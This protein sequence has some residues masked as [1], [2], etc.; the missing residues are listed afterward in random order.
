MTA[1]ELDQERRQTFDLARRALQRWLQAQHA[2]HVAVS[3]ER[4]C[5]AQ[6][7]AM[8]DAVRI[9]KVHEGIDRTLVI[10]WGLQQFRAAA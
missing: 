3:R 6:S 8:H 1:L 5:D 4:L 9:R 10:V 7:A 2:Q